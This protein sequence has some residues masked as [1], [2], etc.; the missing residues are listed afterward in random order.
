M[1]ASR[2]KRISLRHLSFPG[3]GTKSIRPPLDCHQNQLSV[4]QKE[5]GRE[6]HNCSQG[7]HTGH[8]YLKAMVQADM[9][10]NNRK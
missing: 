10:G 2:N 6:S 1:G 9:E 3:S 5:K 7:K 8:P 4:K